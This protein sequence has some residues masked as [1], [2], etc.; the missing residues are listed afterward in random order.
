MRREVE[1]FSFVK[2]RPQGDFIAAF[3]DFRVAL[4]KVGV[5]FFNRASYKR[6]WANSFKHMG[7]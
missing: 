4:K 7:I 3:Q 6:V 5:T 2:N 1:L